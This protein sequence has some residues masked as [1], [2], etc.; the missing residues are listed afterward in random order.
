MISREVVIDLIQEKLDENGEL[1]LVD[2]D[3]TVNNKIS[4][5]IDGDKG[6]NVTTC[7]EISRH[8][9]HN[10]DREE[11][12]YELTVSSAGLDKPLSVLRQYQKN[13]GRSLEVCP[14]EGKPI[15]GELI[16]ADRESFTLRVETREKLEGKKKKVDVITDHIFK[17]SEIKKS[18]VVILFK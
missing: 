4:V 3:I 13:I 16:S 12:D 18:V 6:V 2:F 9:D 8:I 15:K 10:L 11:E 1:F 17:Y 7:I 5:I 14:L